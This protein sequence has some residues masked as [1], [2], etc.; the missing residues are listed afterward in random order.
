MTL[1]PQTRAELFAGR[2]AF[3]RHREDGRP[4]KADYLSPAQLEALHRQPFTQAGVDPVTGEEVRVPGRC[5]LCRADIST[6]YLFA[7]HFV[8]T[9]LRY[10]NLGECPARLT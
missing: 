6:E 1:P 4:V 10:L 2:R 5:S 3:R 9:D 8:V 7:A